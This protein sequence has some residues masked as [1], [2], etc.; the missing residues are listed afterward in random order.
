M[1]FKEKLNLQNII[2]LVFC[3]WAVKSLLAN[4][5]D[6]S[7]HIKAVTFSRVN[8]PIFFWIFIAFGFFGVMSLLYI[9][10]FGTT[11]NDENM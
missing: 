8:E 5:K 1:K 11:R 6:G 7:I 4:I 3:F 2:I 9:V 10:V